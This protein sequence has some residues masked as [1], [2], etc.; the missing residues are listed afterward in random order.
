M[1]ESRKKVCVVGLGNVGTTAA[2]LLAQNGYDLKLYDVVEGL[3]QGR[4]LDIMQAQRALGFTSKVAAVSDLK[5]CSDCD[6]WLITAGKPRMPGMT[7]EQLVSDNLKIIKSIAEKAAF[8][9]KDSIFVLVTNPLDVMVTAF[10]RLTGF[11]R[12]RVLGM[13]AILDASRMA[14]FISEMKG[15]PAK[16]IEAWVL[17]PH[18]DNMVPAFSLTKIEGRSAVEVLNE[19]ERKEIAER[20]INGGAEIVSYLKTGSAFLAPGACAFMLVDSVLKDTKALLP[21]SVYLAGEYGLE[22]ASVAVPCVVG[23]KGIEEIKEL[24]LTSE[25]M[26]KL[27]EGFF[28]VKEAVEKSEI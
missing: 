22:G 14:Y 16:D 7:R 2:F 12:E 17:G 13:G 4:A 28:G 26:G 24:E 10:T 15:I 23:R 19:E 21:V 20:T 27:R 25:E 11:E 5:D 18:S 1:Q 8:A 9:K 6:V 3:S